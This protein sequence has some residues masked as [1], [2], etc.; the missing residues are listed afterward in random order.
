VS[1]DFGFATDVTRAVVALIAQE[2]VTGT[3][4]QLWIIIKSGGNFRNEFE[5]FMA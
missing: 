2:A 3:D 1:Y 5:S 4:T